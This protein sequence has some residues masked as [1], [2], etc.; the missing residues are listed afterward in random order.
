MSDFK[1]DFDGENGVD[2]LFNEGRTHTQGNNLKLVPFTTNSSPNIF[3]DFSGVAGAFSRLMNDK[4]MKL[5]IDIGK[6][7]AK[8]EQLISC[9][10]ENKERL[11]E[12]VKDMFVKDSSIVPFNI[13][14]MSYLESNNFNEKIAMFLYS[15]F[16]ESEI[17]THYQNA[18]KN[19]ESNVLQK[20]VL[21]ALPQLKEGLNSED[22]KYDCFLPY[23][24][25]VFQND[26]LYMINNPELYE[27]NIR[28]FLEYYFLFYITQLAIKLSRFEKADI[29]EIEKVYMT[30]S[31]EVTSKT[32]HAY[33][34]GWRY[35][36][37]YIPKLFSH[38]VT[39]EFLSRNNM[40]CGMDYIQFFDMFKDSED[41]VVMAES[42]TK[43]TNRYKEWIT[44]VDYT[45]CLHDD[46]KDGNCKSSNET[47]ILFETIEYQFVNGTRKS[48]Y[49][50]YSGR[51]LEFVHCNFGKRRGALGY[52]FNITEQDIILFTK[53]ILGQNDGRMRLV[54]MF[55][56]FERR[57]L[58]FDRDS[59]K[60]IVELYEKLNLLEK[61]SDSG[62]A[63]YVKSI[64]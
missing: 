57:G 34:Y 26:I 5:S 24:Q 27:K 18:C 22:S 3:N 28:R 21:E 14:T 35:A 11:L 2:K 60:K 20:L 30:L 51:F 53:I 38:A 9:S 48:P 52:T 25:D 45:L 50:K 55:N 46:K 37:E 23:V 56:E 31:W 12:M 41:D 47:R 29:E 44:N 17:K 49:Q 15:M 64:L 62:D 32:R 39:L 16:I 19:E 59:K 61:K 33:I 7:Y 43:I 13:K 8:L 36:I 63:Q 58:I 42:I 4:K 6:F 54:K 10:E 40:N 1:I